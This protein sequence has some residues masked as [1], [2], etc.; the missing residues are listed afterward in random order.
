MDDPIKIIERFIE[1]M[2]MNVCTYTQVHKN[3]DFLEEKYLFF[4]YGDSES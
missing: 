4:T 3:E 1:E 2:Y